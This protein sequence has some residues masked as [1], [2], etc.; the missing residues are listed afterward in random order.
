MVN[1]LRSQVSD[2][3]EGRRLRKAPQSSIP[4]K[5]IIPNSSGQFEGE[6]QT[7]PVVSHVATMQTVKAKEKKECKGAARGEEE[8]EKEGGEGEPRDWARWQCSDA[9][10]VR[11]SYW[12][13]QVVSTFTGI[14]F[15]MGTVRKLGGGILKSVRV[16]GTVPVMWCMLPWMVC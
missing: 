4:A 8:G 7:S 11:S 2:W 9:A 16:A 12:R 5:R 3:P 13:C 10:G 14:S 1:A 15:L 6:S